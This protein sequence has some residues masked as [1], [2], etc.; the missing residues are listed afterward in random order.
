MARQRKRPPRRLPY[1][2]RII[3]AR[4]RL[5]I[6]IALGIVVM[7]LLPSEWRT[8]TRIV[9]G[10]DAGVALYLALTFGL[11]ARSF[12]ALPCATSTRSGITSARSS[13]TFHRS[14]ATTTSDPAGM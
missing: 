7:V 9:A 11:M 2:L 6:S 1:V 10:W 14:S 12:A 8:S 3:H 4:P 13:T 5:V